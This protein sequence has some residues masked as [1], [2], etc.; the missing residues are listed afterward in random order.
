MK[1]GGTSV[2]SAERIRNL[3]KIVKDN[4]DRNPI[5]VVSAFNGVTDHL[6]NLA[7]NALKG[8]V[9]LD[10]I[11]NRH[12][13]VIEELGLSFEI[14]KDEFN[15]L[16]MVLKGISYLKEVNPRILDLVMSFGERISS[17]IIAE[18]LKETGIN[19]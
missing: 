5:V 7:Y 14:V 8:E 1:F 3:S 19:A 16:E 10:W 11:I 4:I 15:E 6:I 18:Y 9:N 13:K 2:G 17:K 12:L